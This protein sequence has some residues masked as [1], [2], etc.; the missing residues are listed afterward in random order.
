MNI[1]LISCILLTVA[2]ATLMIMYRRG[3]LLQSEFT[4]PPNYEP[5]TRITVV[6]PAR[7]EAANIGPCIESVLAQIYSS[8]L[9]EV[10]VVDDHSED[11]TAAIAAE[12]T[13]RNVRC[14]SLSD[15][16]KDNE[17][18]HAYKKAAISAGIAQAAGELIV[19]TDADC[20]APNMWLRYIAARYEQTGADMIV[21]PVQYKARNTILQLFQ[22]IDF[23]SMQGITAAA[24]ALKLGNMSN[25]A[26]LAFR[27][28]AFKEVGGYEGINHLA[29]GDDY[30]LMM[31]I[32]KQNPASISYLKSN[33]ATVTTPAQPDWQSFL[34]QRIR[35]A[36]KS[37]KY[38][39]TR[40]TLV[41]LLVYAFN[42]MVLL[43]SLSS[44]FHP[45]LQFTA[46]VVVAVKIFAEYYYLQPVAHFFGQDRALWYFPFLQ[47]LH[48][49]YIVL[50]GFLGFV[51]VYEWKGRKVK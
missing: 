14:I 46:A 45:A 32:H 50:A 51:G 12:Y 48:V 8:Y 37:G 40:L 35:W 11:N 23:M 44:F 33:L 16:L 42:M 24:H 7:N 41:L 13:D 9:L 19:T 18:T 34:Q 31:K 21:A 2:Y 38:N 17:P 20:T 3:W 27:K 4:V 5:A 15:H 25:G 47:P 30:L 36:S 29:S 43:L 1:V 39:D 49:I 28:A 6:I 22:L 26:N 10:I